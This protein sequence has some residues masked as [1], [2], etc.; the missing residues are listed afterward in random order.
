MLHWYHNAKIL[1]LGVLG[2]VIFPLRN[3][4]VSSYGDKYNYFMKEGNELVA[5]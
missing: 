1:C 2:V 4:C 3:I 5:F